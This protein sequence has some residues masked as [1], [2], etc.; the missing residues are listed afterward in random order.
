MNDAKVGLSLLKAGFRLNPFGTHSW[1]LAEKKGSLSLKRLVSGMK[2]HQMFADILRFLKY[3]NN[4]FSAGVKKR[5]SPLMSLTLPE[6][7]G[8]F[9]E[10]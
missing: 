10:S 9:T 4:W 7:R 6:N 3:L 8:N 1:W 2:N 5:K